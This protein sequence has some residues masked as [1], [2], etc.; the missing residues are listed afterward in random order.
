MAG[1]QARLDGPEGGTDKRTNVRTNERT[2][3]KSPHSTGLR[4]LSGPL[5]KKEG[6][7]EKKEGKN[8]EMGGKRLKTQ[9]GNEKLIMC[10]FSIE[11]SY[12]QEALL[13]SFVGQ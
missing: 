7:R 12:V 3:G 11:R 1:L 4:P 13:L 9:N 10:L 8:E 5:P 6:G 2:D